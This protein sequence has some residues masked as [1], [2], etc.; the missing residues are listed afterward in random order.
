MFVHTFLML[1]Y[2][3]KLLDSVNCQIARS[4]SSKKFQK[5]KRK[6]KNVHVCSNFGQN[7]HVRAMCVRPKIECVN[8]RATP[9]S[10]ATHTLEF[11]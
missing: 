1:F 2:H 9:K 4:K 7:A 10:V 6:L 3:Q 8:V 11:S 5:N